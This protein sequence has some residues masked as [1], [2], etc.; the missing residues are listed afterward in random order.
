MYAMHSLANIPSVDIS[1]VI[2]ASI[3]QSTAQAKL[4]AAFR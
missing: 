4:A 1:T 2:L 3:F